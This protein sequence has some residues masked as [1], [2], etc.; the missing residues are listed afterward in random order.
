[1]LSGPWLH[2]ETELLDVVFRCST[3]LTLTYVGKELWITQRSGTARG[4]LPRGEKCDSA[5]WCF[6]HD[7]RAYLSAHPFREHSV[8]LPV[9]MNRLKRSQVMSVCAEV[10][11]GP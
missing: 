8:R 9:F 2:S 10:L 5:V 6:F 4:Q 1:M 3:G 11:A 7:M